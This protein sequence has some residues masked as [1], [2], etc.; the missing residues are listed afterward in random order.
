VISTHRHQSTREP[1]TALWLG[2][3]EIAPARVGYAYRKI[4]GLPN[5]EGWKKLVYRLYREEGLTL[6]SK[7]RPLVGREFGISETARFESE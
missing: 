1:R 5:R 7:P 2:N 6:R 4:R 3:R